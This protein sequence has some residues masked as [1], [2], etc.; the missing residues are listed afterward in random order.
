M[1]HRQFARIA[2][3]FLAAAVA[4]LPVSG[5]AQEVRIAEE[6]ATILLKAIGDSPAV[7]RAIDATFGKGSAE[8]LHFTSLPP[9]ERGLAAIQN[10]TLVMQVLK[11]DA[12]GTSQKLEWAGAVNSLR[13]S[14]R[15]TDLPSISEPGLIQDG[16]VS[17]G[18]V[19]PKRV[20]SISP[21]GDVKIEPG[22][23]IPLITHRSNVM[24][25]DLSTVPAGKIGLGAVA[26]VQTSCWS[27]VLRDLRPVL[28]SPD[29]PAPAPP[30]A[31]AIDLYN[32]SGEATPPGGYR[33]YGEPPGS[34]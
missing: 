14:Y 19:Q 23:K 6:A 28:G 32:F 8:A 25:F 2:L 30:R 33:P 16:N 21:F 15:L 10:D 27:H 20:F 26:C 22:I 7:A 4:V 29:K 13:L 11:D 5:K 17:Q 9:A 34:R 12:L 24:Q 31:P 18:V 1:P 3:A